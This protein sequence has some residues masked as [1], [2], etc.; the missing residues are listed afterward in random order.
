MITA[1]TANIA[2]TADATIGATDREV[3]KS[4]GVVH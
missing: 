3:L 2:T 1:T 4:V